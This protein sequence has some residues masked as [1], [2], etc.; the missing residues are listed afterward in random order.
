MSPKPLVRVARAPCLCVCVGG[1]PKPDRAE[2]EPGVGPEQFGGTYRVTTFPYILVGVRSHL[3][4]C[5]SVPVTFRLCPTFFLLYYCQVKCI[6][7][8]FNFHIIKQDYIHIYSLHA[9]FAYNIS[10]NY[11]YPILVGPNA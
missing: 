10:S 8:K 11:Y 5:P 6:N 2:S 7:T 1:G 9:A 4:V 3:G